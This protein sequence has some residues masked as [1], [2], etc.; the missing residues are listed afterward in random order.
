MAYHMDDRNYLITFLS[1][2]VFL[3]TLILTNFTMRYYELAYVIEIY[4]T[5]DF[6]MALKKGTPEALRK[7]KCIVIFMKSF[8]NLLALSSAVCYIYANIRL[9]NDFDYEDA[10]YK[11][12]DEIKYDK[13]F[14]Y[15]GF[16]Q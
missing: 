4:F 2:L 11:S 8:I 5:N 12:M 13:K 7:N 9:A 16:L 6:E 15:A 3:Q 14:I 1:A 10:D